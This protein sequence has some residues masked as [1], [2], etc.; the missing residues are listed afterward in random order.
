MVLTVLIYG[1]GVSGA[2]ITARVVDDTSVRWV[3]GV[4]LPGIHGIARGIA[5]AGSWWAIEITVWLLTVA[6]VASSGAG[7]TW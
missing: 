2:A 6:L 7:A 4:D 1:N 5:Y 3:S